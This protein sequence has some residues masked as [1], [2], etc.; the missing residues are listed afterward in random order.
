MNYKVTIEATLRKALTIDAHSK[1]DAVALA[2]KRAYETL[3][4]HPRIRNFENDTVVEVETISVIPVQT[5]SSITS[6]TT[7]DFATGEILENK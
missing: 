6:V 2:E 1:E 4:F 5:R 7:T 3:D